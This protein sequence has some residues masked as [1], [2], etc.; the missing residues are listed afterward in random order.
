MDGEKQVCYEISE[1]TKYLIIA[2]DRLWHHGIR[3]DGCHYADDIFRCIFFNV[4]LWI[5]SKISLKYVPQ[6]LIDNEPALV[7]IKAWCQIG[8]KPLCEPLIAWFADA[9]MHHLALTHCGLVTPL[10]DID[11]GQHW[12][13]NWLVAWWPQT[14]TWT[15]VDLIISKIQLYSSDGNFTSDTSVIN[16]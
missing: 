15:N 4:N 7:Q 9:Y 5:L 3:Q 13:R 16:D 8:D 1:Y 11:L 10:G 2:S 6:N 12:L 14:I